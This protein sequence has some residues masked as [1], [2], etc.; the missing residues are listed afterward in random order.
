MVNG[1]LSSATYR[2]ARLPG[3]AGDI[4]PPFTIYH[5]PLT[6]LHLPPVMSPPV[7]PRP[8]PCG[9][10]GAL[11]SETYCMRSCERI[12]SRN[13]CSSPARLPCVLLLSVPSMSMH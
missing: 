9:G 3:V 13:C 1:D 10:R 11:V 4:R 5:S 7:K 8:P 12:M 6:P 2:P